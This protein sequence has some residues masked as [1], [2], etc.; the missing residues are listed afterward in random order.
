MISSPEN[1]FDLDGIYPLE[2][3]VV[4][5]LAPTGTPDDDAVFTDI[6]TAWVI[7]GIGHGHEDVVAPEATSDVVAAAA[8]VEYH[9][10]T[11]GNIDTFHFHGDPASY[12][13]SAVVVVPRDTRAGTMLRGRYLDAENPVQ[14]VVPRDVV[15][16]LVDRIFRIKTLLDA[17]TLV[18]GTAALAAIGLAVFL[19]YRLRAPEM[20]TAFKLGA[21]RG[22]ILRLLLSETVVLLGIAGVIAFG[23][24]VAIQSR[25]DAIVAWLLATG[26]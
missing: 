14:L 13:V 3:D 26:T 22:T 6:K 20:Q 23:L 1:L 9:R 2:L 19:T 7:A 24:V 12:P 5:V 17:V 10:I 8:T 21:R 15:G 11:P 25:G 16:E 18:I 4:G